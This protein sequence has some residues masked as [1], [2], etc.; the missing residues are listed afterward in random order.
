[1]AREEHLPVNVQQILMYRMAPIDTND[2][3]LTMPQKNEM[4]PCRAQ[5]V[6]ERYR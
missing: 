3:M 6:K 4:A 2:D 1:M 5:P